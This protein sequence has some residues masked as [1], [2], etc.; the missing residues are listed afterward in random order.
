VL[1]GS[2]KTACHSND[3]ENALTLASMRHVTTGNCCGSKA[4]QHNLEK[5]TLWAP[6]WGGDSPMWCSEFQKCLLIFSVK[7]T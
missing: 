5:P 3:Y 4:A 7:M 1:V 2:F 6:Q